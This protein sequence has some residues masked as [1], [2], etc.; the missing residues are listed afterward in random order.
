VADTLME[1]ASRCPTCKEPGRHA[2]T[3]RPQGLP[4]GTTV[5]VMTCDN[6]RCVQVGENWLIQVNPDGTIPQLSRKGPKTFAMP[7]RHSILAQRAR[8]ELRLIEFMTLHPELSEQEAYRAL[9][10]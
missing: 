9:G 5:K 8:D 7:G 6:K 10:G 3:Q 4:R 1:E 2:G